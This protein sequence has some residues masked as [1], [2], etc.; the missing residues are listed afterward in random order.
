[1]VRARLCCGDGGKQTS[2]QIKSAQA[3]MTALTV[4]HPLNSAVLPAG[5]RVDLEHTLT[6]RHSGQH[7]HDPVPAMRSAKRV[8]RAEAAHACQNRTLNLLCGKQR[9]VSSRI[10]NGDRKRAVYELPPLQREQAA[11]GR[12][13]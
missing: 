10:R 5:H 9:C 6:L 8:F 2:F 11:G 7:A 12:N 1:M 3:H 4:E 13:N